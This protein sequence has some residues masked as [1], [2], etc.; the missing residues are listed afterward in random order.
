MDHNLHG[1]KISLADLVQR[2]IRRFEVRGLGLFFGPLLGADIKQ[3]GLSIAQQHF[4]RARNCLDSLMEG[5]RFVSGL[6][7]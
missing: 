3:A 5:S 6:L 1:S 4:H 7:P 2:A